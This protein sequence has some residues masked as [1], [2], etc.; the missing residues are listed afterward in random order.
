MTHSFR[1]GAEL[2]N[3]IAGIAGK[4]GMV[5]DVHVNR[6]RTLAE[7][8]DGVSLLAD[9]RTLRTGIRDDPEL[10][11]KLRAAGIDV[12]TIDYVLASQLQQSFSLTVGLAVPRNKQEQVSIP[13]GQT[14]TVHLSSSKFQ[15]NRVALLAIGVMLAFLA[16]LLYLAASISARHR[17]SRELDYAASRAQHEP[18]PLM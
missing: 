18:H 3:V 2:S 9:L 11:A 13:A 4:N 15:L 14:E 1:N 8:T 6:S 10:A 5:R 12:N 7:D 16:L 17:R